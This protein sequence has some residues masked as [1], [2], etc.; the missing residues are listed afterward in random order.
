MTHDATQFVLV[1]RHEEALYLR[2]SPSSIGSRGGPARNLL[3]LRASAWRSP[4]RLRNTQAERQRGERANS[5]DRKRG[6]EA[7][8]ARQLQWID[9]SPSA[10]RATGPRSS[11]RSPAMRYTPITAPNISREVRSATIAAGAGARY[12]SAMPRPVLMAS[13]FKKLGDHA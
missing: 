1:D 3:E 12:P 6:L 10:P 2:L 13:R 7:E 4:E 8:P 9:A 11:P 5:G